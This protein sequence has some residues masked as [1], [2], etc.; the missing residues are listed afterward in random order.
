M[1]DNMQPVYFVRFDSP[2][3]TSLIYYPWQVDRRYKQYY[4]QM[5]IIVSSFDAIVGCGA[6]K[7]YTALALQTIS[8]HFR[9]LRD[10]ISGQIQS[11]RKALGEQES[12][13]TKGCGISRLRYVDQHLKQ[14]RAMQQ[15]GMMQPHAWRP[16]R[17][18]P[19][20]SVSI[21]RAWLFEH[22]LHPYALTTTYP[23]IPP[24]VLFFYRL[25]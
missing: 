25:F 9:S 23:L 20:T 14:Q 24:L 21:L 4:H 8:W 12:S 10:A 11:T 13:S 15:L 1:S 22:F 2:S 6:A 19:E 5:Q 18:L 17:G 16:Q 7:P 3:I